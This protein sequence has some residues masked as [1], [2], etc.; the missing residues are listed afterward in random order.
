MNSS[1]FHFSPTII[2]TQRQFIPNQWTLSSNLFHHSKAISDIWKN[3]FHSKQ[4]GIFAL[5]FLIGLS[6]QLAKQWLTT[7]CWILITVIDKQ[8]LVM[9]IRCRLV[10]FVMEQFF[11]I[12]IGRR[13]GHYFNLDVRSRRWFISYSI[14]LKCNFSQ[15]EG[16]L[17]IC[18]GAHKNHQQALW[19][20]PSSKLTKHQVPLGSIVLNTPTDQEYV[21]KSGSKCI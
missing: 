5:G 1:N 19:G 15:L 6:C 10:E 4:V 20:V 16:R 11:K 9:F 7:C 14:E 17:R 12:W 18:W 21:F 3:F 2:P 13:R 8:C